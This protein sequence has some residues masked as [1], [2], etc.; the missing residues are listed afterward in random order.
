[1]IPIVSRLAPQ[2]AGGRSLLNLSDRARA[3]FRGLSQSPPARVQSYNVVCPEGHRLRGERTVAYQSIRCP[4]CGEA[5]FVLPRSPLPDPPVP[6]HRPR[7]HTPVTAG[8]IDLEPTAIAL[9]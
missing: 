5:V 2:D 6:A 8:P 1:M 7:A 3:L 4:A 9:T